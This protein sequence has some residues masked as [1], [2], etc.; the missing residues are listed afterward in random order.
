MQRNRRAWTSQI[1][2]LVGV[3]C[4]LT[5]GMLGCEPEKPPPECIPGENPCEE[6]FECHGGKCVMVSECDENRPCEGEN[7]ACQDGKC[8]EAPPECYDN[9]DCR[10][11]Y[12]CKDGECTNECDPND[13]LSGF[14][15]QEGIMVR[16]VVEVD[17]GCNCSINSV[18]FDYNRYFI[19]SDA[20]SALEEDIAC[21][22]CMFER[23][24]I[25][26]ISI[27]GHA[28][29]RGS[30]QYNLAL[31]EKRARAMKRF[32][33]NQGLNARKIQIVGYGEEYASSCSS[34][35][36][37]QRDRRGEPKLKKD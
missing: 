24:E 15:C 20:E 16:H 37:W 5:L 27:E 1:I 25:S 4:M 10:E 35:S 19:R 13:V 28:D 18:Y 26:G 32:M 31:S 22:K 14:D 23:E 9:E 17:L 33:V 7:M 11:G 34:E 8:V 3:A 2:L 36:C 6:G 29:E 30:N 21:Y 12:L